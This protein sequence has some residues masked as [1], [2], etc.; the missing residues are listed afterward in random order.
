MTGVGEVAGLAG[1]VVSLVLWWPQALVVWRCRRDPDGLGGVS[2]S[3][4]VLLLA[5]AVLWGVYA[6]ATDSLWVGAPGL[7]NAPLALV[8]ISILRRAAR[9]RC[10]HPLDAGVAARPQAPV[11]L[12]RRRR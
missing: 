1:S 10:S 9:S 6:L 2:V 7:V 5:N 3:S 8:T 11:P 12:S 4:Q